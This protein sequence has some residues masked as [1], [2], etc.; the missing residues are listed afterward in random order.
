[1]CIYRKS[2]CES[3]RQ[4]FDPTG[5]KIIDFQLLFERTNTDVS[6]L[7]ESDFDAK[8]HLKKKIIQNRRK[9]MKF[10][11]KIIENH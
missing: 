6:I 4:K 10:H 7:S 1:M 9:I 3:E 11:R 8:K 5:P 2:E